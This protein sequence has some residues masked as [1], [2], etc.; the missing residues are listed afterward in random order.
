MK[1]PADC[2][3][4][5]KALANVQAGAPGYEPFLQMQAAEA[6]AKAN[7]QAAKDAEVEEWKEMETMSARHAYDRAA[8]FARQAMRA[9][10]AS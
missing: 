6:Q 5:D 2:I 3:A 7:L 10:D 1:R 8:F 4:A 9:A